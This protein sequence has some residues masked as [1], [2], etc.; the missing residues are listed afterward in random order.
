[1]SA[2]TDAGADVTP[3]A[4][5]PDRTPP[6][7]MAQRAHAPCSLRGSAVPRTA[8]ASAEPRGVGI[9]WTGCSRIGRDPAPVV[10]TWRFDALTDDCS[11]TRAG[12]ADGRPRSRPGTGGAWQAPLALAASEG[13]GRSRP[14]P[15]HAAAFRGGGP[16]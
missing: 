7:A 15:P 1:G 6:G 16:R 4:F 3:R 5:A 9:F 8:P 14:G 11:L 13:S 10:A 2:G 12:R